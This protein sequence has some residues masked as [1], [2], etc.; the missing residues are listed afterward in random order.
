MK[1]FILILLMLLTFEAQS[2]ELVYADSL[3]KNINS[4]I[5]FYNKSESLE[6]SEAWQNKDKFIAV[7][8]E[9]LVLDFSETNTWANLE[10]LNNEKTNQKI[11]LSFGPAYLGKIELYD[12]SQL[13]TSTGSLISSM[14][15]D[16]VFT[17][18]VL[19]VDLKPGK[20]S[21][22]IKIKSI[23]SS[24]S[25][26]AYSE[27]KFVEKRD[28]YEIIFFL[29]I[30]SI[31]T[32]GLYQ[33]FL[34]LTAKK[35]IYFYYSLYSVA[36]IA[37]QFT[38]TG[39]F[40]LLPE[41]LL[42]GFPIGYLG[43]LLFANVALYSLIAFTYEMLE[44]S[45]SKA[46]KYIFSTLKVLLLF[47]AT[48][49]VVTQ[50]SLS[51]PITR[52]LGLVSVLLLL[53][54]SLLEL[55]NKSYNAKL[56]LVSWTPLL[57]AIGVTILVLNGVL[58]SSFFTDWVM[59]ICAVLESL[60]LAFA[61]GKR[62]EN[63][64]KTIISEQNLKIKAYEQIEENFAKLK[65]RDAI[66]KSYVSPTILTEVALRKD[67]LS[68]EPRNLKKCIIFCDIRD[69]TTLT[70][71]SKTEEAASLLN[72][73]F[74]AM[75]EAVFTNNGE[76]DKLIGDAV[77][78]TF[79]EPEDCLRAVTAFREKFREINEERIANG[80]NPIYVGIGIS[81]GE[82]LAAN[83]GSK[84]KLDRTIVGD[85]VNV[86]SRLDGL[87]K[88]YKVD[89]VCTQ[90]FIEQIKSCSNFRPLDIVKVKG[91]SE[92]LTVFE[93]FSHAS[94]RVKMYKLAT[95]PVLEKMIENQKLKQYKKC[96]IAINDLIN[97]NPQHTYKTNEILDS[98]LYTILQSLEIK[99]HMQEDV[100]VSKKN[101][102]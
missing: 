37:C 95:K 60:V 90:S 79:D 51:I 46:Y 34:F 17:N 29:L 69:Y 31:A 28:L 25:V 84:Y 13:L 72:K 81:Y 38:L 4:E 59:S 76:V 1:N 33:L 49:V 22:M 97:S 91:K 43:S 64:D 50:N 19:S 36:L 6:L 9:N 77:M 98:A 52:F 21:L 88:A 12:K 94:D 44:L 93:I 11:F 80:V 100:N 45:S 8:T 86:A 7:E 5:T 62:L 67:P 48:Y 56:F 32:L 89:V 92:E 58:A 24:I 61:L 40:H 57:F 75:N 3:S 23:G 85:A 35:I 27:K 87:S 66:I 101:A 71:K 42:F 68:Y 82:V 73:F 18:Q 55:R 41:N 74:E 47:S 2:R 96:K 30:G 99:D 78:A 54:S 20:N 14:P 63:A 10:V 15:R 16:L 53:S 102:A 39:Y 26:T 65:E 70:E 83:F